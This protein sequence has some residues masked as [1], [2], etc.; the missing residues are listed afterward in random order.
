[1]VYTDTVWSP[2]PNANASSPSI[3]TDD[4]LISPW[5]AFSLPL[6]RSRP[7]VIY[8][9]LVGMCQGTP[10]DFRPE[11]FRLELSLASSTLWKR[12]RTGFTLNTFVDSCGRRVGGLVGDSG[13]LPEKFKAMWLGHACFLVELP[14]PL[15][16]LADR[17]SCP[18][19]IML[20]ACPI[21]QLPEV[22][23]IVISHCHYH[24]LDIPTIKS[25][26]FRTSKPTSIAPLKNIYLFPSLPIPF[27]NYHCLDW[28]HN[29]DITVQLP[30]TP[31][32][33]KCEST[34]STTPPT[35]STTFHLHCTP[36][37]H[38]GNRHLFDRWTALWGSWAVQSNPLN[39]MTLQPINEPMEIKSSG[40]AATTG[41]GACTMA[42]MRMDCLFVLCSRRLA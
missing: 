23:A 27:S 25:V 24:H 20:P 13:R 17:G 21:Q 6:S 30:A 32:T 1:M 12:F 8:G 34:I 4:D 31:S 42:R 41:S 18:G 5:V 37:Q 29:H 2:I 38:W 40:S 33:S 9:K 11:P 26:I 22:N 14:T 3:G 7:M 35:V 39:P 15:A 10:P 19:H 36:A 16:Q 28:W